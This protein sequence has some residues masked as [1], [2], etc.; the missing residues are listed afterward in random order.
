[1]IDL[2]PGEDFTPSSDVKSQWLHTPKQKKSEANITINGIFGTSGYDRCIWALVFVMAIESITLYLLSDYSNGNSTIISWVTF[3]AFVD[4]LCATFSHSSQNMICLLENKI[5]IENDPFKIQGLLNGRVDGHSRDEVK[6]LKY[7]KGWQK[8]WFAVIILLATLKCIAFWNW[9]RFSEGA[10]L[11]TLIGVCVLYLF[12]AYLHIKFIGFIFYTI[13]F[14]WKLT[15]QY[16]KYLSSEAM[17]KQYSYDPNPPGH[18]FTSDIA[19][20]PAHQAKQSIIKEP[21]T[22]KQYR[23]RAFG[24]LTDKELILLTHDQDTVEQKRI[25]LIEGIKYQISLLNL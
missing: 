9:F 23:I 12:E 13:I 21:G 18:L 2:N 10:P 8:F 19:I 17:K 14:K 5:A 15:S 1:M 11:I 7:F 3:A 22:D 6:G 24:I 16:K 25:V 20:K 4:I